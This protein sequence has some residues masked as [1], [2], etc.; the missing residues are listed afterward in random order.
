MKT[1]HLRYCVSVFEAQLDHEMAYYKQ[2][3]EA[4]KK[5]TE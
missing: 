5:A 1:A 4:I 3:V 2:A